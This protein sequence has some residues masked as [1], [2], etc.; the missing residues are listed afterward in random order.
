MPYSFIF[1]GAGASRPFEIPTMQEMVDEFESFLEA[2]DMKLFSLYTDIKQIQSE[3]YKSR[4]VDIESVYSV[5]YGLAKGTPLDEMGHLSFYYMAKKFDVKNF[6]ISNQEEAKELQKIMEVFIKSKCKS[7]L[8]DAEI[9]KMYETTYDPFFTLLDTER[10]GYSGNRAYAMHWK[11]YGTNYDNVFEDFWHDDITLQDFFVPDGQS[12]NFVFNPNQNP[13]EKCYIKLHGS[14]DWKKRKDDNKVMK[15]APGVSRH[16]IVGDVMI[17]PIQQKDMYLYPWYIQFQHLKNSLNAIP[18][19]Y[20]IG[21]SFNDEFILEIFKEAFTKSTKL[22]IIGPSA[23]KIREKFPK[24]YH[25][26]IFALPIKFGDR[27]FPEQFKNF[28]EQRKLIR[29]KIKTPSQFIGISSTLPLLEA[30]ISPQEKTK[31]D[32]SSFD[33]ATGVARFTVTHPPDVEVEFEL[34]V[35]HKG[36]FDKDLSV[37]LLLNAP[38]PYEMSG[39]VYDKQIITLNGKTQNQ[40]PVTNLYP[41]ETIT[42]KASDL[43]VKT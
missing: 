4:N 7:P 24:D 22:I 14:I 35:V 38:Y 23:D 15:K 10:A 1:L 18:N 29:F 25:D 13:Q 8:S 21:Y 3:G 42:I 20:V 9:I 12:Q 36:P 34:T 27:Y 2:K 43:F 6:K 19:W 16:Q 28:K 32:G 40:D 30:Q 33:P 41:S 26:R 17:F 39:Y 5:V 37:Q 31:V 11:A